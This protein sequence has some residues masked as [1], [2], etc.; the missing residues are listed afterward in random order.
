MHLG[1]GPREGDLPS[2]IQVNVHVRRCMYD[3][4]C[5]YSMSL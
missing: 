1:I 2:E 5:S 4:D 3:L